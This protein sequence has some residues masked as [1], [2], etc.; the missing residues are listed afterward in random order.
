MKESK[1][2]RE[3]SNVTIKDIAKKLGVSFS[4]VAKAL[5]NDPVVAEK[6]RIR[7]REKANEMGY[8]PNLMAIGLR[9]KSTRSIGMIL[10]DLENP[11]RSYILKKISMDM[12]GQGFTPFIFDSAYDQEIERQNIY[13]LLSRMPDGILISPVSSQFTNIDLL[14]KVYD[15]TIILSIENKKMPSN[16]VHMDHIKGGNIAA[17]A[18]LSMGHIQNL[19]IMEPQDYPS[20][21]Q[22]RTGVLQAYKELR[23]P[24]AEDHFIYT[25]PNMEGG[26]KAF[27]NFYESARKKKD[28]PITGIIA[29]N[30]LIAVGVYKAAKNIGLKIPDDISIIGYD[31]LPIASL[32]TP[33]LSTL[34]YPKEKIAD[35]CTDILLSKILNNDPNIFKFSLEPDIVMRESIKD[36]S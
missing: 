23:K 31:D 28:Q 3:A 13:N 12:V 29:S 11:T 35:H 6:T 21:V 9:S 34:I 8:F 33:R 32:V 16:Y 5:N 15:R 30:D 22:F 10:N 14:E 18:M 36:I 24:L 20:A 26:E 17:S 2:M 19:I 4:T 7:V 25:Y 27:L 1:T